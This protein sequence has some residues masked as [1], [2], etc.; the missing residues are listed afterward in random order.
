MDVGGPSIVCRAVMAVV[1]A[2]GLAAGCGGD[3][4]T[5]PTDY[6]WDLPEGF[7]EPTVPDDNPMTDDKV[8]LGRHLFYDTR[9]S[10]DESMSCASC[11]P[12]QRAFSGRRPRAVGAT[13]QE[14]SRTAMSLTNVAYNASFNWANPH[15]NSLEEQALIPMFGDEPVELGLHNID[16][17]WQQRFRDDPGYEE[18]FQ[19]AFPEADT[20]VTF[21]QVTRALA[22]FERTLISGNSDFDRYTY[23][24]EE[25]AMSKSARRGMALFF[26]ERLECFHCHGGFNFTADVDHQGNVFSS[27]SFHNT[28]LYNYDH[29]GSYP[30]DNRGLYEFTGRERDMGRFRAPTLRNIEYTAPYMHDG[31]I[32]TLDGVIDHYEAGGRTVDSGPYGGDGSQNPFKSPF[33][34]GFRLTDEE[35]EDLKNF[36]QSL[37]DP[38]FIDDPALSDP[39]DES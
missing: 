10:V 23:R 5:T 11:H 2:A 4:D 20:L 29:L 15:I 30:P 26:S 28:G 1:I 8:E 3:V 25:S 17:V 9:L 34:V 24:G 7:P 13:G 22:S 27:P 33:M 19:R 35:R 36:L 16:G 39:F 6:Q 31:S 21:E 14:H 18:M 37:S 38:D 12:Q 32:E